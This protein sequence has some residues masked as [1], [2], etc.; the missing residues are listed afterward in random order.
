MSQLKAA[1]IAFIFILTVGQARAALLTF[2]ASAIG[3][4]N[5]DSFRTTTTLSG[6]VTADST[7]GLFSSAQ[8][9]LTAFAS[10][11]TNIISQEQTAADYDVLLQNQN[12]DK[13]DLKLSLA[14]LSLIANNGGLINDG[15]VTSSAG[16]LSVFAISGDLSPSTTGGPSPIPLPAALPLFATGLGA[17][18]LLGWR[19]KRNAQPV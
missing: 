9:I 15:T 5:A 8:L 1:I 18:G 16:R 13:L 11:F 19:R 12:A 10:P 4:L 6:T 14:P 7:S 3:I 17:L 2:E